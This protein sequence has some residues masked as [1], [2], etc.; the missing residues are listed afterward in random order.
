MTTFAI[1][2][3]MDYDVAIEAL[4]RWAAATDDVRAVVLTGSA[5]AGGAHA[6]SDRDLE[7]Y[8]RDP[9]AVKL[10]VELAERTAERLGLNG[11]AH[12]PASEEVDRI[13]AIR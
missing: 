11:F 5:A 6:L 12:G 8:V 9:D 2:A 7:L 10:F 4:L 1:V 3:G 13:L